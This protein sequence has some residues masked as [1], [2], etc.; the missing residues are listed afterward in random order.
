M[1]VLER[2]DS[3]EVTET[4]RGVVSVVRIMLV[5]GFSKKLVK[6]FGL[7]RKLADIFSNGVVIGLPWQS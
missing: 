6:L 3:P 4:R 5:G 7:I 2:I 1:L